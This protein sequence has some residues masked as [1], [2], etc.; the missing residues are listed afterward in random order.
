MNHTR[1]RSPRPS[2]RRPVRS[3][4]KRQTTSGFRFNFKMRWLV[5][6]LIFLPFGSHIASLDAQVRHHFEGERWA[7]PAR[8][9]ARP[10]EIYTG[11]NL[12]RTALIEE[13]DSLGYRKIEQTLEAGHYSYKGNDELRLIT[14]PFH[15]WDADEASQQIQVSFS[16]NRVAAIRNIATQQN[17]A[18]ARIEPRLIGKIYPI[19]NQDRLLVTLE[20]IPA[21]LIS[22]LLATEDRSFYSHMGISFRGIMRAAVENFKAGEMVQGGSTITQQL[23][24]NFYLTPERKMARKLNEAAMAMLLE[25]H[26]TK[27]QI[28]EAYLNEVNMGQD[29]D[30]AIH[31][32][33]VGAQFYFNRPIEELK[34]HEIALLISVVRA[35]SYYNPR[36]HP[37]RTLQ[38]RNMILDLMA[39]QKMI[40]PAQALE[41]KTQPL[42]VV[43][44]VQDSAFPYPAFLEVVRRQLRED[45]REEDLR[46]E[47]LQ[48]F[49]TLDPILQKQAEK[50]MVEGIKRLEKENKQ[51]VKNL[52]GAIVISNNENGELLAVVNGKKPHYAGFNR[53]LNATRPIGS[54]VKAAI[55]LAALEQPSLYSLTST[56]SDTPYE[57]T[58]KNTGEKW[59]PQNYDYRS[60]GNVPLFKALSYSYNLATVRLGMELGL[61]KVYNTLRKM[62]IERE[63]PI[64]PSMLLGSVSLT[65]LEVTQMYQTIAS[66]GFRIPVRA[67]RDVLKHDGQPLQRYALSVEQRFDSAAIF[68]L[69]Y[70]LQQ[71]VRQGTGR[72]VAQDIPNDMILAGKTGTTN[73]L[74]DSWFAGF[75]SELLTVVWLGRDD[76]KSMGLSGSSGAM[77]IWGDF[78]KSVRPAA[79]KPLTPTRVRWK[80]VDDRSGHSS[81]KG[82]AGA[83]LM[84]YIIGRE[85]NT[86]AEIF[87]K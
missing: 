37:D 36:K 30:R 81:R 42:G 76:N 11:M 69:N 75:G 64:Y 85:S 26:Y 34:L 45:Y 16:G 73:D 61:D 7:L 55:Y 3:I 68:L 19:D 43:D 32:M 86:L 48:I 78:I 80:W 84:P 67:I 24:K 63:F 12:S 44:E 27:K 49:T 56:L 17:I 22:A 25:F 54:L 2:Q 14:R 57:W 21:L 35:P 38:R 40:M 65:P 5:V 62:G 77:R 9:Y 33:G 72:L 20:D 60:H 10:L 18:L 28:L 23:V 8:V 47:G 52:E 87:D 6:I 15:F 41:A 58:D 82:A 74:R 50:S 70:A 1:K 31:G 13:L 83:V 39:E 29:G 66:G 71:A 46:S 4:P 51:R 59:N 53:P 79:E